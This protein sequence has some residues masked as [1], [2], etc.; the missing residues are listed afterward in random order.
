MQD[1]WSDDVLDIEVHIFIRFIPYFLDNFI[2]NYAN[3]AS[4]RNEG[5]KKQCL[6]ACQQQL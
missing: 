1:E 5:L 2:H 4:W 6:E 3:I